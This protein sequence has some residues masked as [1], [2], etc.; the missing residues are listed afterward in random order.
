M[1]IRCKFGIC[2]ASELV[3]DGLSEAPNGDIVFATTKKCPK[4]QKEVNIPWPIERQKEWLKRN[5]LDQRFL[6]SSGK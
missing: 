4:C 2:N 5:G 6:S 3:N 1:S